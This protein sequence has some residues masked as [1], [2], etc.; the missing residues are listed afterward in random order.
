TLFAAQAGN[1]RSFDSGGAT[2]APPPLRMTIRGKSAKAAIAGGLCSFNPVALVVFVAGA[3]PRHELAN[4][5]ASAGRR[6]GRRSFVG[7]D[8]AARGLYATHGT[9]AESHF[10]FGRV[11]LNDLEFELLAGFQLDGLALRVRRFRVV[12]Q[13]FDAIGNLDERAEAGQA[14]HLAMDDI[15]HV[16]LLEKGVP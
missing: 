7:L 13:A 4:R 9:N 12:A 8:L 14:Q 5:R 15:A 11:H 16:M 1:R 2:P 6:G 3:L 10:L